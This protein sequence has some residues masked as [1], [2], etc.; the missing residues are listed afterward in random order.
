MIEINDKKYAKNEKE[1][2]QS[3][4]NKGGTCDGYYKVK[5]KKN[6]TL[7]LLTDAKGEEFAYALKGN[8]GD[9]IIG[10]KHKEYYMYDLTDYHRRKLGIED[11]GYRAT[12]DLA[13]SIINQIK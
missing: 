11:L 5:R 3:L 4:F 9:Y 10:T 12:I 2:S 6:K 7:V 13:E 1:F 8:K